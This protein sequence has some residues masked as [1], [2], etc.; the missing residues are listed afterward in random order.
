MAASDTRQ[1]E[2]YLTG[3]EVAASHA[4]LHTEQTK[5]I[6]NHVEG[7][8]QHGYSI[9]AIADCA[10]VVFSSLRRLQRLHGAVC[11]RTSTSLGRVLAVSEK[12]MWNYV[13]SAEGRYRVPA[14]RVRHHIHNLQSTEEALHGVARA[15]GV[16]TGTLTCVMNGTSRTLSW[17]N[18]TALLGLT[19]SHLERSR[20]RLDAAVVRTHLDR[21]RAQGFTFT[22]MA[23]VSQVHP[24]ALAALC[25]GKRVY[26]SRCTYEAVLEVTPE[27]ICRRRGYVDSAT[28]QR[29][30]I[31]LLNASS[32]SRVA[33]LLEI[34]P[35]R[36][37]R[38]ATGKPRWIGSALESRVLALD[39]YIA[40]EESGQSVP[41]GLTRQ[42][43]QSLVAMGYPLYYISS[44]IGAKVLSTNLPPRIRRWKAAAIRD[45]YLDLSDAPGP[46]AQSR[47][48][49]HQS[50]WLWPLAWDDPRTLAWP[51][52]WPRAPR[53]RKRTLAA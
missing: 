10:N 6:Y 52:Q 8:R 18:A 14:R 42:R 2:N 16:D 44:R 21:L 37:Q 35:E 38:L 25:R 30:L 22:D 41:S 29:H 51:P 1:P 5:A 13:L 31:E 26:V 17:V 32:T 34:G 28:A 20:R 47:R 24:V 4:F 12:D 45:L 11:P 27:R 3:D 40:R 15:A 43:L 39:P 33:T 50:G 19:H 53:P 9:Q 49:A 48:I 36:V 23:S 7:L 46:S